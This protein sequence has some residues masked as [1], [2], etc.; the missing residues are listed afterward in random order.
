MVRLDYF[1]KQ[2]Y[3]YNKPLLT[4]GANGNRPRYD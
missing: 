2:G 1:I 4:A 3:T